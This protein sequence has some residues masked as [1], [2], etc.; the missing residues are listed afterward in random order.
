MNESVVSISGL[1]RTFRE[2]VALKNISL[3]VPAGVVWGLVGE[4]GAGKTTLLKHMLGLLRAQQGTVRVLGYDPV[5]SPVEVLGQ[6]GYLSEERDL[7]DW[8]R[9]DELLSYTRA[10]YPNWD[11][12]MAESLREAFQLP[13]HQKVKTFSRGQRAR[14]GLLVALAHR[15]SLLLLDEPSTGLDPAVRR[16]IL[17]AIIRTVADEGRTVVFSSHLLDEVQRVAD[18]V[19]MLHRGE[20]LVSA[21]LDELIGT[22]ARLVLRF[23]EPKSS[24]PDL[25]GMLSCVGEGREWT[26][27][28]NGQQELLL[29]R[30]NELGGE[31]VDRQAATL[32]DVFLARCSRSAFRESSHA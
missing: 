10:F 5:R 3:D 13:K 2:Q 14:T 16:D 9:L 21:P 8:M 4:N 6:M 19:T 26:V 28:C 29:N 17:A 27:V 1:F 23:A 12:A 15:P 30:L 25:P 32:D 31:V 18:H 24:R 20:V 22:H 7:P 11:D